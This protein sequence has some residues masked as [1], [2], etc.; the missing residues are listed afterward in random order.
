MVEPAKVIFSVRN[1]NLVVPWPR[2]HN[3][4]YFGME[5]EEIRYTN[6]QYPRAKRPTKASTETPAGGR[7]SPAAVVPS[8]TSLSLEDEGWNRLTIVLDFCTFNGTKKNSNST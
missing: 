8:A 2:L 4:G 1:W 7:P 3:D 6:Y 5:P